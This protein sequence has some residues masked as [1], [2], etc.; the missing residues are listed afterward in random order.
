MAAGRTKA[1]AAGLAV[2]AVVLAIGAPVVA[3]A[4]PVPGSPAYMARDVRNMVDAF[5]RDTAELT[6]PAYVA[7]LPVTVARQYVTQLRAQA[8]DATSPA[9]TGGNLVPGWN[10]GNPDRAG[11]AGRRGRER[12]VRFTA[13]DGALLVGHLY[14]PLAGARDP[15]TGA[16]L[17]ATMPGVVMVSGSIQASAGVYSW[18]A[19]DLAERGYLVLLFDVQGQG[20]SETFPHEGPVA[21]LPGCGSG[22]GA[23]QATPCAGV[24][25][26]QQAN[27]DDDAED[28]ITFFLSTP[29]TPYANTAVGTRH[30]DGFNPW[31]ALFD[32]TPDPASATPGRTTRLA[33]IGHST[34]AVTASYLQGVDSRIEAAVALDK[35]TATPNAIEDD[36]AE[37]GSLPGPV[38]PVVPI[39]GMQSE[40]GFEPQPY[41]EA[42]CSSFEPCPAAPGGGVSIPDLRQAPDPNREEATGFDTWVADG[43]DS[44]VVVPRASTHLDYTDEPPILPASVW[45]QAMASYYVQAWLAKYLQHDTTADGRLLTSSI[46]YLEPVGHGVWKPITVARD[47]HLSFYFCSGYAF[48]TAGGGTAVDHDIVGDGC[49]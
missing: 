1:A 11:W 21:A 46:P 37:L 6:S 35:I 25:A 14:A 28:A 22:G 9:I 20:Q 17:P 40:Y 12:L 41:W 29:G 47:A 16:V 8:A 34:G 45:G 15:Y 26:E 36:K 18:L 23:D 13:A 2:V 5:G 31:W 4:G 33:L 49:H 7:G 30:V 48:H 24:P 32:R 19:E 27:F 43:V 44:M 42:S 38:T 10:A 3:G 39:L